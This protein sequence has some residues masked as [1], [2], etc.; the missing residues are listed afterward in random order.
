MARFFIIEEPDGHLL[1]GNPKVIVQIYET[2]KVRICIFTI[3]TN[4]HAQ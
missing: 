1:I 4:I 3:K 2:I